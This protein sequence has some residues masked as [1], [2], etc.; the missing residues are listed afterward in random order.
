MRQGEIDPREV[1]RFALS[2]FEIL[3]PNA[4]LDSQQRGFLELIRGRDVY[5]RVGR[6]RMNDEGVQELA[7]ELSGLRERGFIASFQVVEA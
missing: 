3:H 2:C 4:G 6:D 7:R 1:E 5:F